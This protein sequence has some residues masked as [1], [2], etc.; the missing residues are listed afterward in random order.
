MTDVPPDS[1]DAPRPP[2]RK[3]RVPFRR[4]RARPRRVKDWTDRAKQAEEYE[5]DSTAVE[6]VAAKGALS[7]HR[8]IVVRA[9]GASGAGMHDGVVVA[10]RGLMAEVDDAGVTWSCSTRRVLRTRSIEGRHPVTVGDQV[11]YRR[12]EERGAG[13]LEGV[14]EDV[15]PRRS[16]L[17]RVVRNR[18]HTIAA[19]V[20]QALIVASLRQPE[21]K[22][23]LIDRY[24]VAALH[25][26]IV[27]LLCLTKADLVDDDSAAAIVECYRSLDYHVFTAS[28][29]TGA[30]IEELRGL[31]HGRS[32]VLA[33]QSG[34]GKS[35]LLNAMEPG[36][37]LRVG[38][39]VEQTQKGRH[40]TTTATLLRLACGGF[41]VD[42]P[43]VKSLDITAVPRGQFE[44]YFVE[45]LPHISRCRF[46]DCSHTHEID[47]VVKSAVE[48]GAIRPERYESYVRMLDDPGA[49]AD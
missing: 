10:V 44:E 1:P 2:G 25:G 31:L 16:E 37:G 42:T 46:P 17:R 8:T 9:D 20:D 14:I 7:R 26:N 40:T 28:T 5:V 27:P 15:A 45:F 6:N 43:G 35:S 23:H 49:P 34:V 19:N 11:R 18:V 3:V 38:T 13:A 36:L 47:C 41:V 4:N 29:V 24:I 33:G 12:V 48:S 22:R 30:G 39:I 32:T 21:P